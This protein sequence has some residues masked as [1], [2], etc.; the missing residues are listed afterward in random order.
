MLCKLR[1]ACLAVCVVT[2]AADIGG[3]CGKSSDGPVLGGVDV[4]DLMDTYER[5]GTVKT[6]EKG[7][8]DYSQTVG[9]EEYVFYFLSDANA[10]KFS[11]NTTKYVPHTGGY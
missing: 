9:S 8:S 2:A 3:T 4:V 11:A 10:Q 5:S 6:P 7:T 1:N